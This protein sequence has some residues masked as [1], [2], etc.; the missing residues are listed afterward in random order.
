MNTPY[1]PFSFFNSSIVPSEEAVIPIMTNALQY[2]TGVFAGIRGYYN[3]EKKTLSVF[4]PRDHFD[5]M[6]QSLRIL[7]VTLPYT[8]DNLIGFLTDLVKKNLPEQNCYFRPFAY[9]SSLLLSPNLARDNQ[10]AFAMYMIPLEDYLPTDKGLKVIVSSWKRIPDTIIPARA[11]I[12]GAYINS[13]LARKEAAD[14]GCDEAVMLTESG[15]I[16]E[17]SAENIFIVRKGTL[18]TPPVTDD[19]LEGITRATIC[20]IARKKGFPV[21]ERT[22]DRSELYIAEEA[23]FSGTGVQCAWISEIDNRII[24][25]GTLGKIT[26]ILRDTYFA[27][28][29]GEVPE[30]APLCLP[31]S[32]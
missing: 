6:L 28:V 14:R 26:S 9:A 29:R 18:I 25:S 2:G 10:F 31:I 5:R 20:E 17:G 12:M 23:F 15:H 21:E 8:T 1:F 22:I 24:G 27:A 19:I 11:K 16:S 30:Y 7:G 4:R 32:Y 13:A 3:T